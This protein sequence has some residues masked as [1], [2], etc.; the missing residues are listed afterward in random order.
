MLFDRERT[1]Q[2][3][4]GY[5]PVDDDFNPSVDLENSTVDA[6]T[7]TPYQDRDGEIVLPGAYDLDIDTYIANPILLLSHNHK[8]LP[9]GKCIHY[10]TGEKGLKQRFKISST[11]TGREV[12]TLFNEGI[13]RAFSPGFVPIDFV[14]NPPSNIIPKEFLKTS[15]GKRTKRIYRRVE[16]IEVSA[17]AIPSNR[18]A[19][20]LQVEKGNRVA[21][22]VIKMYAPSTPP[23][24][25]ERIFNEIEEYENKKKT[26]YCF[27]EKGAGL[28]F[29]VQN[30]DKISSVFGGSEPD[31]VNMNDHEKILMNQMMTQ[32]AI[33]DLRSKLESG[34]FSGRETWADWAK[35]WGGIAVAGVLANAFLRRTN[36]GQALTSSAKDYVKTWINSKLGGATKVGVFF[37]KG[38]E[39]E[40]VS[41]AKEMTDSLD[42]I[43]EFLQKGRELG[44]DKTPEYEILS[45]KISLMTD[46]LKNLATEDDNLMKGFSSFITK[47]MTSE[48]FIESEHPRASDGQFTDKPGEQVS[49]QTKVATLTTPPSHPKEIV[50]D[51]PDHV[52]KHQ[53]QS[54]PH[55][56]NESQSYKDKVFNWVSQNKGKSMAIVGVSLAAAP[57]AFMTAKFGGR[58]V[59]MVYSSRVG[60]LIPWSRL[61]IQQKKSMFQHAE[62]GD[63]WIWG[64]EK[65]S[66]IGQI[67]SDVNLM[68]EAN[69]VK[70]SLEA[71]NASGEEIY[72]AL[73]S[74]LGKEKADE[75]YRA[76][77]RLADLPQKIVSGSE[78]AHSNLV[79]GK[80]D[81]KYLNKIEEL[82]KTKIGKKVISSFLR[83]TGMNEGIKEEVRKSLISLNPTGLTQDLRNRL[84]KELDGFPVVA[85]GH[86]TNYEGLIEFHVATGPGVFGISGHGAIVKTKLTPE[87][88]QKL[89]DGVFNTV[90]TRTKESYS[91]SKGAGEPKLNYDLAT[92]SLGDPIL[93]N[94][95]RRYGTAKVKY[96]KSGEEGEEVLC[97]GLAAHLLKKYGGVEHG[98]KSVRHVS[99]K[100]ILDNKNITDAIVRPETGKEVVEHGLGTGQAVATGA[101]IGTG[102]II[103]GEMAYEKLSKGFSD[104][105]TKSMSKEEFVESEHPRAT[106][107]KFTDKP[108]S[109]PAPKPGESKSTHGGTRIGAGRLPNKAS[110]AVET[111][112]ER[113]RQDNPNLT[114]NQLRDK[115]RADAVR[116]GK[117]DWVAYLDNPVEYMKREQQEAI[118]AARSKYN[119]AKIRKQTVRIGDVN[120]GDIVS[121]SMESK[122]R[123]DRDVAKASTLREAWQT[124]TDENAERDDVNNAKLVLGIG[125]LASLFAFGALMVGRPN[126]TRQGLTGIKRRYADLIQNPLK[127]GEEIFVRNISDAESGLNK[128]IDPTWLRLEKVMGGTAGGNPVG[129]IKRWLGRTIAKMENRENPE[130]FAAVGLGGKWWGIKD[131]M[132]PQKTYAVMLKK[133]SASGKS[134]NLDAYIP[135]AGDFD[136]ATGAR[137]VKENKKPDWA[138]ILNNN[139]HLDGVLIRPLT[140]KEIAEGSKPKFIKFDEPYFS[141][142]GVKSGKSGQQIPFTS[143]EDI[144]SGQQLGAKLVTKE[145]DQFV[146]SPYASDEQLEEWALNT[147]L[148]TMKNGVVT[149]REELLPELLGR[150]YPEDKMQKLLERAEAYKGWREFMNSMLGPTSRKVLAGLTATGA[151]GGGAAYY[152]HQDVASF[153][154]AVKEERLRR[155]K[156]EKAVATK[157]KQ[158]QDPELLKIRAQTAFSKQETERV[159]RSAAYHDKAAAEWDRRLAFMEGI[160][161]LGLSA[162]EVPGT[163]TPDEMLRQMKT[164]LE[165]AGVP[166]HV[167]NR[168]PDAVIRY[169][170]TAHLG[171]E[172]SD[173]EKK[174][175]QTAVEEEVTNIT[176]RSFNDI[177]AEIIIKSLSESKKRDIPKPIL[178]DVMSDTLAEDIVEQIIDMSKVCQIMIENGIPG[179]SKFE[180]V[181]GM[182]NDF[183]VNLKQAVEGSS[184]ESVAKGFFFFI[185]KAAPQMMNASLDRSG[186]LFTPETIGL[187][188]LKWCPR[189]LRHV[190]EEQVAKCE[191][192]NCPFSFKESIVGDTKPPDIKEKETNE[193]VSEGGQK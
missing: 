41:E 143:T 26:F 4:K 104:L 20:V 181:L 43:L 107:G 155:E 123:F 164:P 179:H 157:Y 187:D 11:D 141:P 74:K 153:A 8:S 186:G 178:L 45:N 191:N 44:L 89:A 136:L 182:L 64:A 76:G 165:A 175:A 75:F 69:K 124:Y 154:D 170:E 21:D 145:G 121:S 94:L 173:E 5:L 34:D 156:L 125:A 78:Y 171:K 98:Y 72:N 15:K 95:S 61:T 126:L 57:V 47:E 27:I 87:Q 185:K 51:I 142:F 102:A 1:S 108:G 149:P 161:R 169:L 114:D 71:K 134:P 110:L 90:A 100:D 53:I 172:L 2:I 3:N 113:Y 56:E 52:I 62:A 168:G 131:M 166:K 140:A 118:D 39:E 60:K 13:L 101:G 120:T 77:E 23:S 22:L 144:K 129:S 189:C 138:G 67:I 66:G 70:S 6:Y 16:L 148:A 86:N 29:L 167:L 80:F 28:N 117:P 73:V 119:A 115:V 12:L 33:N 163:L 112:V 190:T 83:D 84:L 25:L 133:Q 17:L 152:F 36:T 105:V 183:Y 192:P 139:K 180:S 9:V 49:S 103:G 48:E 46:E 193:E 31:F 38:M 177:E 18:D 176:Q 159:K 63:L 109:G 150:Q 135:M 188:Y 132:N 32:Q 81:E 137:L 79:I 30:R 93:S 55:L 10:E 111:K 7:S 158:T 59:D 106:D 127:E 54:T 91:L 99:V 146:I 19:L 40:G 116:L 174:T 58:M 88:R 42:V 24:E 50:Q 162:P 68:R 65:H 128:I 85:R 35:K 151:I 130:D 160:H 37:R 97:T 82:A 122:A 184:T 92:T 14:D 147:G 96:S